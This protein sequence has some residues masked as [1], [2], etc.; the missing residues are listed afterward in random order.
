MFPG[1]W[2]DHG[3]VSGADD[4][5]D[6][7]DVAEAFGIFYLSGDLGVVVGLDDNRFSPVSERFDKIQY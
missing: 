6:E 1:G 5:G 3:A 7:H 4:F 2:A